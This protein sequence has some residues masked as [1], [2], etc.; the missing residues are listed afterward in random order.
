VTIQEKVRLMIAGTSLAVG[1]A[2]T[3][4]SYDEKECGHFAFW[5]DAKRQ[6]E[7]QSMARLKW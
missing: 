6:G 7:W 3:R 4:W 5:K 2:V 1:N